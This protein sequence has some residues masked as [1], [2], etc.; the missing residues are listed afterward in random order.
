MKKYYAIGDSIPASK[1]EDKDAIKASI[2]LDGEMVVC[3]NYKDAVLIATK[4]APETE[5]H[6]FPICEV[7]FKGNKGRKVGHYDV[8]GKTLN[9]GIYNITPNETDGFV[10][11]KGST[12]HVDAK[13][14]EFDFTVAAAKDVTAK[15]AD[16]AA[17]PADEAAKPADEA[18]KPA[19]EAAKPADEAAK[20][21]TAEDNAKKSESNNYKTAAY[22][23]AGVAVVS[24]G[25]WF[26]GFY[27]ATAA[28]LANAGVTLPFAA[29]GVQVGVAV[30]VG[31]AVV[32]LASLGYYGFNKLFGTAK[33]AEAAKD[34]AV[35]PVVEDNRTEDQKY[36]DELKAKE[37]E[38]KALEAKLTE[39]EDKDFLSKLN[40]ILDV[41]HTEER[42]FK[43]DGAPMQR[44]PAATDKLMVLSFEAQQLK[45]VAD[46]AEAK[47]R[48]E[49]EAKVL[50]AAKTA[51][52]NKFVA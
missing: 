24:T 46:I 32:A 7:E 28:F 31:V 25:F 19:D 51:A 5:G 44:Q 36:H 22:A 49:Q 23:V 15:P 40:A 12:K 27:P 38:V 20:P 43:K 50:E 48:A 13:N 26:S 18:A 10:L 45:A 17:K 9:K 2:N 4:T 37:E 8:D 29:V 42:K 21:A 34:E 47:A 33:P 35:K 41:E 14:T 11:V 30:A 52:A 39:Q 6:I 3:A 16:E 1:A